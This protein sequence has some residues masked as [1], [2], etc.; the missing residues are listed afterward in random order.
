MGKHDSSLTRVAPVFDELLSRDGTG[1]AWIPELLRLPRFGHPDASVRLDALWDRRG[2]PGR[3][4]SLARIFT[5]ATRLEIAF[6]QMGW[7][8]GLD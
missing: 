2:G 5:Q 1:K 4:E 6:W 8:A 3:F 7:D